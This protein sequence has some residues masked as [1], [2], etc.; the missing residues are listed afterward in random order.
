MIGQ[1]A[2]N[3]H[4][5]GKRIVRRAVA[6]DGELQDAIMHVAMGSRTR[7]TIEEIDALNDALDACTLPLSQWLQNR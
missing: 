2:F 4:D 7:W 1:P 6:I 3:I 5:H